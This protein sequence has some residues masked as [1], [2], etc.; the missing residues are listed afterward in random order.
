MF[1]RLTAHLFYKIAILVVLFSVLLTAV[2]F[3]TVDYYYVEH[4][5]LLDA[6][7]LYFYSHVIDA[8]DFPNNLE[9]I[10][11]ELDNLHMKVTFIDINNKSNVVWAYP[12]TIDP[13]GYLNYID[14]EDTEALH[15]VK[16]PFFVSV[17][18]TPINQFITYAQKD[19]FHVFLAIDEKYANIS[20]EYINYFPPIVVSIV[21]MVVFYTFIRRFLRPISLMKKRIKKM[22]NGDMKSSITILGNDE[23]AELSESINKMIA[24]IK[25]LLSQKQQLLL[26]VSHE[27]RSPLARMRLLVE[28]LPNHK[29]QSR[30][31]D[32]IV[33]L[34]GMISNL[35]FSDKLSLPYSN[36]DCAYIKTSHIIS[37]VIDLVNIDLSKISIVN[38][39]PLEKIWVDEMKIII[40]LRNLI[41][42]ALKYGDLKEPITICVSKPNQSTCVIKVSNT[43]SKIDAQDLKQI[44]Q[45]FFRSRKNQNKTPGFGLGLTIC[46]KIIE[47]HRG[48][49]A[50]HSDDIKTT[51]SIEIPSKKQ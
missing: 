47:A 14:S 27:L 6:H 34:E 12:D 32:E 1:R 8:W 37:K 7:E 23:L 15:G 46:K 26:D 49:L 45:P 2:I 29:N 13:T 25:I 11:Q 31:V 33:F 38:N 19:S 39:I 17:G 16:N 4:D 44:F 5:T 51:F 41:D 24:D 42:N 35:L 10:Q 20:P 48:H 3:Y 50:I 21:F 22:R 36:L 40:T 43:G 30:L 9:K 18:S 28:M